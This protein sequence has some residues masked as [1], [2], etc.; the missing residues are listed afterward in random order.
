MAVQRQIDINSQIE[1]LGVK[2]ADAE[3]VL[4]GLEA[5]LAKEL[6]EIEAALQAEIEAYKEILGPGR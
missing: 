6:D 1:A 5:K 4:A 3:K 2:P